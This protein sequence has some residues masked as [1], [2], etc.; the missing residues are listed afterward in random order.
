MDSL[1]KAVTEYGIPTVANQKKVIIDI[2]E[3][4]GADEELR[5]DVRHHLGHRWYKLYPNRNN[6]HLLDWNILEFN[7]CKRF[8]QPK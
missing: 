1:T 5:S 2:G 8:F 7:L 3:T 6:T 4:Q